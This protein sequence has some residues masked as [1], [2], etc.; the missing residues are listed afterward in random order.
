MP[1]VLPGGEAK[2]ASVRNE[3]RAPRQQKHLIYAVGKLIVWPSAYDRIPETNG[4]RL[5]GP[6]YP[7]RD[8]LARCDGNFLLLRQTTNQRGSAMI[9]LQCI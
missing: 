5:S 3:Y 7:R 9:Q 8:S 2:W 4:E 1:R 6:L